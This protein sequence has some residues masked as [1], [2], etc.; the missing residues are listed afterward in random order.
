MADLS[1]DLKKNSASQNDFLVIDGDL[2]LTSDAEQ[3]GS[4]NVLQDILTR[5]RFFAGEWFM[6]TTQG[7]PWF[8]Q[9][10]IKNPDQSKIDALFQNTI[11]GTPGVQQLLA[12]SFEPNFAAR[13]LTVS[14][15]ANTTQG[16]VDYTG[17]LSPV[18]S[19]G[20]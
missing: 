2:V 18:T 4:N 16:R 19:G 13:V 12:Y 7:L 6:D 3:G 10:L 20:T 1:L 11:M 17:T 8:Q 14:F 9:I 15:T 5:I